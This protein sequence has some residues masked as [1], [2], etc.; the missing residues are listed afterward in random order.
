MMAKIR[1][2]PKTAAIGVAVLLATIPA[3]VNAQPN[4]DQGPRISANDLG[5]VVT[6]ASAPEAGVWV[7]AETTGLP[8]PFAKIVVTDDQGRYVIPDLPQ[9]NYDV[10]VRG[11]GLVDSPRVITTP[12]K[13]VNLKAVAAPNAAATAQYYPAI[14]WYSM[15]NIP[16]ES[17]FSG[18][19]RDES[20]P[21]NIKTHTAWLNTIKTTGCIACH[22]IGTPG[23]RTISA[24]LGH[25]DTSAEAWARRIQSGQADTNMVNT[26]NRLDPRLAFQYFGDWTDRIAAGELP[27]AQPARPQGVERN[28]VISL[29]DWAGPK[30]YLHDEIS[31][32]KRRPTV[33]A[34]GPLYGATEESTERLPVLDPIRATKRQIVMPVRDPKTPSAKDLPKL[35]A[36]PYWGEEQIWD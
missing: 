18:P 8:T 14:Y 36:S 32:D 15:L 30:D 20:M 12:G 27:F 6:G 11:Y 29:W 9:A 31:T 21:E 4:S 33:N 5:G 1:I 28:V 22:G 10:W 19:N 16:D 25:F 2:L 23:T 13:I 34:R 24:E 3:R 35:G 17:N 26:I 7:I